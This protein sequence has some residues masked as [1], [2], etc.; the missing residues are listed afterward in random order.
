MAKNSLMN[1][2]SIFI[3]ASLLAISCSS[4]KLI[5]LNGVDFELFTPPGTK[6]IADN[7]FLDK[8]VVSISGYCLY[9]EWMKIVHGDT[10]AVFI[11]TKPDTLFIKKDIIDSLIYYPSVHY[12]PII[13]ISY[14][15][16]KLYTEW[17]TNRVAEMYLIKSRRVKI[18]KE[19]DPQ[20]QFTIEKY[21]A[22]NYEFT[23]KKEKQ[24]HFPIYSIPYEDE[25][26]KY[27][28]GAIKNDLIKQSSVQEI[29][30]VR[31]S[32]E[33]SKMNPIQSETLLDSLDVFINTSVGNGNDHTGFRNIC[34]WQ[35]FAAV[36]HSKD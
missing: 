14:D 17:R 23:T 16:A 32:S 19:P 10:S 7:L 13:G 2:V 22:D 28:Y 1:N 24:Y 18:N 29:V 21:L 25:W 36:D 8:N 35:S 27:I 9:M 6:Q 20:K 12:L 11:K 31:K 34:T 33:F 26:K 15:Q 30:I 3:L 5:T 4:R